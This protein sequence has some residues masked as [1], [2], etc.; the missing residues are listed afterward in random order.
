MSLVKQIVTTCHRCGTGI[1]NVYIF[2]G[3]PYGSECI[4]VVTGQPLNYWELKNGEI[5]VEATNS[6]EQIKAE[7]LAN[8]KMNDNKLKQEFALAYEKYTVLNSWL[9]KILL[10][11]NND[12]CNSIA[13]EI[14]S[15][16][17]KSLSGGQLDAVLNI[18][19]K[20]FK[21]RYDSKKYWKLVDEFCN[22]IGTDTW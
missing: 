4:K 8:K 5:D 3:K 20:H 1:K 17:I 7:K 9:I 16:E 2:E 14:K 13:E 12:F 18:Y 15:R 11:K 19:T 6:R 10:D 22:K 21:A